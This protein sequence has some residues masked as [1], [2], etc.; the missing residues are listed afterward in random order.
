M[1]DHARMRF[2]CTLHPAVSM[3]YFVCV[4]GLTL[5]CPHVVTVLLSLLGSTL[6]N[7]ALR[8]RKA[9]GRTMRFVLPMFLL[10]CVAPQS[11]GK[12]WMVLGVCAAL[13]VIFNVILFRRSIFRRKAVTK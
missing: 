13:F 1:T 10:V 12:S 8:G 9:F 2:F 7:L 11:V 6:F 4:I 3:C 5:A